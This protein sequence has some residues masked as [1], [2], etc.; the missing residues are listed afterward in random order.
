M[1]LQERINAFIK[2]GDFIQQ[3]SNEDIQKDDKVE[4]NDLCFSMVLNINL[5]LA[6]EHNGWFTQDNITVCY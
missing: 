6:E 5:K 4:H 3:F 2:L 1:Q